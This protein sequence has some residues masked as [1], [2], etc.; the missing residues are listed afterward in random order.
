MF[1]NPATVSCGFTGCKA[2]PFTYGTQIHTDFTDLKEQSLTWKRVACM[3]ALSQQRQTAL[4]FPQEDDRFLP[5]VRK[6][7]KF[8]SIPQIL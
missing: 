1:E 5:F 7:K 8:F 6:G 4:L 2:K 3:E